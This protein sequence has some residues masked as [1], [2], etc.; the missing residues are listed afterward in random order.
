M[1]LLWLLGENVTKRAFFVIDKLNYVMISRELSECK[2]DLHRMSD[3]EFAS[4]ISFGCWLLKRLKSFVFIL[5]ENSLVF[6]LWDGI[7]NIDPTWE[8]QQTE[9][10]FLLER[11]TPHLKQQKRI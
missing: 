3:K 6:N 10:Q 2:T 1:S 8:C 7:S 5:S 9:L 11:V 4:Q